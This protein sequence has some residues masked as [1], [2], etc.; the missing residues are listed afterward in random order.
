MFKHKF[1]GDYIELTIKT[2]KLLVLKPQTYMNLSGHAVQQFL[3][4]Y[5]IPIKD[6]IVI[7]DDIDLEVGKIKVKTGGGNGGHN[8]LRSI[9]D[10]IGKEYQR[11]RVGVARPSG[12]KDVSSHV[13][14]KFTT[15]EFEIIENSIMAIIENIVILLADDAEKFMNKCALKVNKFKE[16]MKDGI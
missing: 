16:G 10:L 5:K 12:L 3:Q 14:T 9:D 13:L 15:R 1:S 7:H 11:I 6:L 4:F 8:G 2:H